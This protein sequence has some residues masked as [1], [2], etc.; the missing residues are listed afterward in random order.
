MALSRRAEFA[1]VEI[2]PRL[3]MQ[4]GMFGA[5]FFLLGLLTLPTVLW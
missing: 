2:S 3:R 1:G 4:L 5:V